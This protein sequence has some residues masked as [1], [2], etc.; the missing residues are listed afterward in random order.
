[1]GT[2]WLGM[3][4]EVRG[5][6]SEVRTHVPPV[7]SGISL[8]SLLAHRPPSSLWPLGRQLV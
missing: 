4:V 1:M 7:L 3:E 5:Q 8:V 2:G 6:R